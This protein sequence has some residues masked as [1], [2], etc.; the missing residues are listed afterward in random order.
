MNKIS[1]AVLLGAFLFP[2]ASSAQSIDFVDVQEGSNYEIIKLQNEIA[3]L[4]KK[5]TA[6][7]DKVKNIEETY[8]TAAAAEAAAMDAPE[9]DVKSA[10]VNSA[11]ASA[12]AEKTAVKP[13]VT[14]E[15]TL[16]PAPAKRY[17]PVKKPKNEGNTRGRR[18]FIR[19]EIS[20]GKEIYYAGIRSSDTIGF[21]DAGTVYSGFNDK[22]IYVFPDALANN[23][24]LNADD[25]AKD[26]KM[27]KCLKSV[28]TDVANPDQDIKD[29]VKAMFNDALVQETTQA[30]VSG[31][32]SKNSAANFE[33]DVLDGLKE[34]SSKATEERS[35]LE[36]MTLTD[37]EALKTRY[38]IIEVYSAML[39]YQALKNLNDFEV[40]SQELTKVDE[41][42]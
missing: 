38:K 4:S 15:V 2:L 6:L 3:G 9:T 21:G 41:K 20:D 18:P 7:E 22:N 36:V 29:H 40:R 30:V 28:L 19:S 27:E 10:A 14:E 32:Q 5:R 25:A 24:E 17:N 31:V 16:P 23:C 35:D 12:G 26:G 34:K 39:K 13:V 33:A 11:A 8:G 37:M 42:S 1:Y